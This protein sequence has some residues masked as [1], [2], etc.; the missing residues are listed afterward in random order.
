MI[1]CFFFSSRRRHT[2][3]HGDWSSDAC[4][5]DLVAKRSQPFEKALRRLVYTAL[6]LDRLD[7]HG[8][9]LRAN[10][11]FCGFEISEGGVDH[12]SEERRVVKECGYGWR[13]KYVV[14]KY[15]KSSA[16]SEE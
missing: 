1:F 11:R 5:S 8:S 4:S 9:C 14:K 15:T 2:R 16:R 3:L 6:A 13:G 10:Q 12:R 7:Q